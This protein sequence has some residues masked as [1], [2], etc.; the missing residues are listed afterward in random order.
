M[1]HSFPTGRRE[2]GSQLRRSHGRPRARPHKRLRIDAALEGQHVRN[3]AGI[4][5]EAEHRRVVRA[6]ADEDD[7][8][9]LGVDVD[10]ED[11]VG[12]PAR[13][14]QLVIGSIPAIDMDGG[15]LGDGAFLFED[16][17]DSVDVRDRK[18]WHILAKIDCEVG[19]AIELVRGDCRPLHLGEDAG[20]HP[21]ELLPVGG[22]LGIGDGEAAAH[23]ASR[24]VIG[25]IEGAVFADDARDRPHAGDHVAPSCRPAGIGATA[26]PA[27]VRRSTAS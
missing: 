13:H 22:A 6:V 17:L 27:S 4:G 10:A 18:R 24:S 26:T 2:C 11:V 19:L 21:G 20:A 9:A 1:L 12:K 8:V 15:D 14:G 3:A 25:E 5:K 16:A 23:A 7:P